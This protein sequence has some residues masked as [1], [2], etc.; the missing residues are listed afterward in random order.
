M[1]YLFIPGELLQSDVPAR[2][3]NLSFVIERGIKVEA[4]AQVSELRQKLQQAKDQVEEGYAEGR[5][6]EAQLLEAQDLL[7]ASQKR[8]AEVQADLDQKS[9]ALATAQQVCGGLRSGLLMA[10]DRPVI[11]NLD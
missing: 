6:A 2:R 9:A 11:C 5:K 7:A 1:L 8:A 3:N 10:M 4:L